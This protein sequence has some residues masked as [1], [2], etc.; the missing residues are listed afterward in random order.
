MNNVATAAARLMPI[1]DVRKSRKTYPT[2]DPS[3]AV[4][5][6]FPSAFTPEQSD[7]FLM[8]DVYGPN[9]ADRKAKNEDDFPIGWH[10][11][12][13]MDLL[14]Y[15][16]EGRGRH[17]DS[18]GNRETF[19]GPGMQW[20]SA[21]SGV[22]HAEGG[23][24]DAHEPMFGFQIWV[25]VP[26]VNKMDDPRYGTEPD[27]VIPKLVESAD[28]KVRLLAGPYGAHVG[29]FKTVA[30]V[31]MVDA[32]LGAGQS[33]LH[34]GI[35][36]SMDNTLVVCYKGSGTVNGAAMAAHSV[37]RLKAGDGV[38]DRQVQ[39][40]AGDE[41]G[42]FMFFSGKMLKEKVAWRGPIVMASD[43]DLMLA[44]QE[45]Q[46]GTFLKKRVS[47]DYKREASRPKQ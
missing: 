5:Q 44:Y 18:M 9:G 20:M 37:A 41:G 15:I 42:S 1:M 32:Q 36:E 17:G 46:T 35:P 25:N 38:T 2:G 45:L 12:R 27:T 31:Q 34:E 19:T 3:F 23:A 33:F 39:L 13:G 7:P 47:W 21:G 16:V 24:N 10:P 30:S 28:A 8:C 43:K 14:T 29:P 4:M 11:H 26:A 22:Y 40:V 6:A